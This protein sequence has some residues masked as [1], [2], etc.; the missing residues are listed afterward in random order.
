MHP[1]PNR[2]SL[3]RGAAQEPAQAPASG[4]AEHRSRDGD[5]DGAPD[6]RGARSGG[7]RRGGGRRKREPRRGGRLPLIVLAVVVAL[8]LVGVGVVL[9][10]RSSDDGGGDTAPV[11][12][13]PAAY[14]VRDIGDGSSVNQVLASR[15]DDSLPLNESELFEGHNAEIANADETIVFTIRD[16][17]LTDDCST[18]VWGQDLAGAVEDAGCTQVGRAAYVSETY[19]AV[20]AVFNLADVEASRTLAATMVDPE[21][22]AEG[23]A[24]DAAVRG[25]VLAP[26]GA[27]PFDR[28]GEGYSAS[29]AIVSGHY[30]IVVWVQPISS[31]SV[32]DRVSLAGPLVALAN[33]NDPLLRRVGWARD[34]STD[35]GTDG[36]EGTDTTG[37]TGT[38]GTG[39]TGQTGTDTTGTGGTDTTDTTGTGT[40]GTD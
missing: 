8:A 4:A 35:E 21:D 22:A 40:T 37:T 39:G 3:P 16:S 29:D 1:E 32:D 13:R 31:E 7:R 27:D 12:T 23:E 15:E 17:E 9:F 2:R 11:Q 14:T 19:F 5:P 38:E 30:L 6:G 36:T 18:A 26:S 10:L 28:L 24:A 33:V 25:F 34:G 20:T